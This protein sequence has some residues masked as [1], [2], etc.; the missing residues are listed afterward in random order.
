VEFL[1][2]LWFFDVC[3]FDGVFLMD[4]VDFSEAFLAILKF[5]PEGTKKA[6]RK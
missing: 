6:F 2:N 1:A 3:Y 4:F 5:A